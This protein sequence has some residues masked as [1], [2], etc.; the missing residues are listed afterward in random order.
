MDVRD[1]EG[2]SD[3]SQSGADSAPATAP[4]RY[5]LPAMWPPPPGPLRP[6][7]GGGGALRAGR[8]FIASPRSHER[9]EPSVPPLLSGEGQAGRRRR[10]SPSSQ[11]EGPAR[12]R[13][14]NRS[15]P[16]LY[17]IPALTPRPD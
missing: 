7:R 5:F 6:L 12:A 4:G 8:R 16:S 1:S 10:E 2:R 15:A 14:R 9:S 11:G 17:Q 3:G 13:N